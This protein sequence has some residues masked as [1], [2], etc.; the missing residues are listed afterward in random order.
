MINCN[1]CKANIISYLLES[2]P[3][4]L[5]NIIIFL[6]KQCQKLMLLSISNRSVA[7]E[8]YIVLHIITATQSM[9]NSTMRI[10]KKS[11]C[12]GSTFALFIDSN[13]KMH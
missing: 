4:C 6:H 3:F 8:M 12:R 10:H 13:L 11:N 9:Y 1:R 5:T 2:V 7:V